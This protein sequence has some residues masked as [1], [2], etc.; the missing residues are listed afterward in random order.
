MD[1][2]ERIQDHYRQASS[3]VLSSVDA[4]AHSIALASNM[5]V[6]ALMDGHKILSCGNG[7]SAA[8]AQH[9]SAELLNRFERERPPLPAL[10]LN[11]DG[12]TMTAIG[13]DYHFDQVFSK[14]I[15]ALGVERDLL[16]TLTTS[17]QSDNIRLAINAAHDRGMRVVALTGR[18]GGEVPNLLHS[19]DLEIRVLSQST[20]RIQECHSL[21]IHCLCDAIDWQLFPGGHDQ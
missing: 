13:N 10:C 2:T 17:G 20:P 21:I 6:N 15:K 12:A 11:C 9:F 3:L 16:L 18:D 14:Q 5:I 1:L 4:H 8:D 19:Q 7:G